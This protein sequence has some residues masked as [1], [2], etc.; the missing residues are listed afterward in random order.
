MEVFLYVGDLDEHLNYFTDFL[1]INNCR[2]DIDKGYLGY[3]INMEMDKI[4]LLS[5]HIC[6]FML[7][8]YL[9]DA[10][11]SKVYDEYPCFNTND[12]SKILTEI[13]DKIYRDAV[14]GMQPAAAFL[15]SE[16][17]ETDS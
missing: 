14:A 4:D 5:E 16:R 13:S 7:D 9:K 3:K 11:I 10:V 17:R 1:K 12:A 8:F 6:Q 15:F 2:Y